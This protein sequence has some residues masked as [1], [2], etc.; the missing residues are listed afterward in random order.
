MLK[1]IIGMAVKGY[2][3][4]PKAKRGDKIMDIVCD[5]ERCGV[6]LSDDTVRRYLREAADLLPP[7]ENWEP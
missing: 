7:E 3:F 6:P 1:L 5:L 2:S 4:N